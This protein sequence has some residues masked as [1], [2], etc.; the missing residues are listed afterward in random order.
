MNELN[1]EKRNKERGINYFNQDNYKGI[2]N[3]NFNKIVELRSYYA[4]QLEYGFIDGI[5]WNNYPEQV[6]MAQIQNINYTFNLTT[7]HF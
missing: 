7:P 5:K 1:P 4:D 3:E 6:K 2:E